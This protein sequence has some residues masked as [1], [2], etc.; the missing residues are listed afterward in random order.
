MVQR[1]LVPRSVRPSFDIFIRLGTL[2]TAG[3]ERYRFSLI[4]FEEAICPILGGIEISFDCTNTHPTHQIDWTA[5]FVIGTTATGTTEWLLANNSTS[6][7]VVDVIISRTIAQRF[8]CGFNIGLLICEDGSSQRIRRGFITKF[9]YIL[10][11]F[12]IIN[13]NISVFALVNSYLNNRLLHAAG[14]AS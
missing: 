7:L 1:L 3:I 5:R 2:I 6:W 9:Q 11:L 14:A 12:I 13:I 8:R 4:R 10:K